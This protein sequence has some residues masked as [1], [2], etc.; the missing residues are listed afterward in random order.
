MKKIKT[1]L[2][3]AKG[4]EEF[5]GKECWRYNFVLP[6][7]LS[8]T[9]KK[10]YNFEFPDKT[11]EDIRNGFLSKSGKFKFPGRGWAKVKDIPEFMRKTTDFSGVYTGISI[12]CKFVKDLFVIDFDAGDHSDKNPFFKF[13]QDQETIFI[14]TKKGFHFYFFVPGTPDFTCSTAIQGDDAFGD[15]DILGRKNVPGSFN[16]I[17]ASH[18]EVQNGDDG[19][20]GIKSIPWDNMKEFLNTKRMLGQDKKNDIQSKKEKNETKAI[21]G[22]GVELDKE[23]FEGYLS[24]LRVSDHPTN[25]EKKSRFHYE[26]FCSVGMICKN[27]FDDDEEG[28]DV[29]KVWVR[30]DPL[31]SVSG[32]E[33]GHSH[34]SS[35]YLMEKWESFGEVA[36]PLTWKTLRSWANED[37]PYKNV[38][39]EIFDQSGEYGMVEYMNGFMCLN[40]QTSEIL[41]ENPNETKFYDAAPNCYSIEKA[42]P[43]FE[44]YSIWIEDDKGKKK[45][46]NPFS[47]WMKCPASRHVNRMVFDPTPTAPS[48]VYN[49]FNGFEISKIDVNDLTLREAEEGCSH[50]L[51]HIFNVWCHR[52]KEHFDYVLNWFSFI[53]Q[54]PWIKIGILLAVKSKE[55]AGKGIVFDYMRH[56][57]GG[58][59]YAQINSLDQLIGSH[60]S[61]LEGRLL[62][63]GDEIIW[64][65]DIKG[66]NAMKSIITETEV[67]I[68]EKY[69]ARYKVQNTTAICIASNEDRSLSAR[70][71]DRRSFGLE[72][73]NTWA[74]RQKTPEHK[75]Y[76][77]DISGTNH[78]GI[79]RDKAESFAK[80][81]YERDLTNF[82]PQNAPITEHL[83]EQME[84]NYTPL[85]KFWKGVLNTGRFSIEDKYKKQTRESYIEDGQFGSVEKQRWV[86]YDEDQLIWGNVSPE[87]G[88]GVKTIETHYGKTKTPILSFAFCPK[89]P[90]HYGETSLGKWQTALAGEKVKELGLDLTEEEIKGIPMPIG[91]LSVIAQ[92]RGNKDGFFDPEG[93]H[94][95]PSELMGYAWNKPVDGDGEWM[96]WNGGCY[97]PPPGGGFGPVSEYEPWGLRQ[98]HIQ[99]ETFGKEGMPRMETKYN[100]D[101]TKETGWEIGACFGGSQGNLSWHFDNDVP[102][103]YDMINILKENKHASAQSVQEHFGGEIEGDEKMMRWNHTPI[104]YFRRAKGLRFFKDNEHPK[105]PLADGTPDPERPYMEFRRGLQ[106]IELVEENKDELINYI[107]KWRGGVNALNFGDD[108]VCKD[109]FGPEGQYY[110]K[111]RQEKITTWV[112]DKDWVYNRYKESIGIGYGQDNL[113]AGAFWKGIKEMQGGTHKEGNG[114]VYHSSKL[115]GKDKSRKTWWKFVNLDKNREMFQK[116]AGRIVKWDDE[117][118]DDMPDDWF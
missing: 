23:K 24:R 76:F 87:Y 114:G 74:G 60:N 105:Y 56:I 16:C 67:W 18:H 86:D 53:M 52:N 51:N 78:H 48:D 2:D 59:L 103:M 37:D 49:L 12:Y 91:F 88:N 15:V 43:I 31:I 11:P 62:I 108:L 70:E 41:Y 38:Y 29:W 33:G 7:E 21:C 99:A 34:R 111:K 10:E 72:L 94:S 28:F 42:R 82:I 19:V 117:E 65:G 13:C 69:R 97:T 1:P 50:L 39:Q 115:T 80:V 100:W 54:K 79:S 32:D 27:N 58:R 30:S 4:L 106:D 109:W 118:D 66:A 73:A 46:K 35:K 63:N 5:A 71:G 14:Q 98:D 3:L 84:R 81:L 61:V 45:Q 26:D 55:G 75:A 92:H 17:E 89:N 101:G 6:A 85:Q 116:W 95:L 44:K 83:T 57:L 96:G 8:E 90:D 40:V 47:I 113:D 25:N 110:F 93:R 9:K 22:D 107:K 64:G 36:N 102:E 68:H 20:K 77:C 112:Y 104:A